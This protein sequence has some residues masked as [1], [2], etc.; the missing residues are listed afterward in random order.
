MTA[1]ATTKPK[2]NGSRMGGTSHARRSNFWMLNML[3]AL[4][5]REH[6]LSVTGRCRGRTVIRAADSLSVTMSRE[7]AR[8]RAVLRVGAGLKPVGQCSSHVRAFHRQ[9]DGI[10]RGK[11]DM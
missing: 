9:I 10:R 8:E 6:K 1:P 5:W 7:F 2:S 3:T 4:L 11:L